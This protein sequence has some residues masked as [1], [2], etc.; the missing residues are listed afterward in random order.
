MAIEHG[1]LWL[2]A[3]HHH[4]AAARYQY[5]LGPHRRSVSLPSIFRFVAYSLDPRPRYRR[6]ALISDS[7]RD[8]STEFHIF[9]PH[10]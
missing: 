4:V 2:I 10:F 7:A 5:N 1:S 6:P 8:L 3:R 9:Y